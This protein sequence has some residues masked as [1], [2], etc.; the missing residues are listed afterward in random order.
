MKRYDKRKRRSRE[1]VDARLSALR[2]SRPKPRRKRRS[3]AGPA[4]LGLLL[5]ASV[6][7]AVYFIYATGGEDER[8][9]DG[10]VRVEVVKGDT[11]ESVSRKLEEA[12]IIDSAF[13]FETEARVE[14]HSTEIQAGEYTF[15]PGEDSDE[16]LAKL[17]A[18]AVVPT[19]ETTIP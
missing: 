19:I 16:I 10:P 2:R 12:G 5:V 11:L 18:G 17:I 15:K 8:A 4:M 3:N 9:P 1:E 7:G 14:G 6:L 13:M